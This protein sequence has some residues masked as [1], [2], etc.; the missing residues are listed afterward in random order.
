MQSSDNF[1]HKLDA[2]FWQGNKVFW[3]TIGRSS[4]QKISCC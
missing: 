1:G 3:Q 4:R 2:N